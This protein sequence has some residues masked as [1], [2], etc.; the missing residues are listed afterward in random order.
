MK[1]LFLLSSIKK[2]MWDAIGMIPNFL[3]IY[4]QDLP[5]KISRIYLHKSMA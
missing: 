2:N 4:N 1:P 3:A 5:P